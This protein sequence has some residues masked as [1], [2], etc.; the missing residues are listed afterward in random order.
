MLAGRTWPQIAGVAAEAHWDL[1]SCS[2]ASAPHNT[3]FLQAGGEINNISAVTGSQ[4][5]KAIKAALI[6]LDSVAARLQFCVRASTP[7]SFHP[8]RLLWRV[9]KRLFYSFLFFFW[10]FPTA[11][12][13][14]PRERTEVLTFPTD[15]CCSTLAHQSHASTHLPLSYLFIYFP[16]PFTRL[17]LSV[18]KAALR[19]ARCYYFFFHPCL[20]EEAED[21]KLIVMRNSNPEMFPP[22]VA[23]ALSRLAVEVLKRRDWFYQARKKKKMCR[24]V[25][26]Q[27]D[28]RTVWTLLKFSTALIWACLCTRSL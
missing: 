3:L 1:P 21:R 2:R 6:C 28:L 17:T 23:V 9:N 11:E 12:S 7:L 5:N 26:K 18:W 22:T 10:L 14:L 20:T 8:T 25:N 13:C 15:L 4:L 27:S 24:S 16:L 19:W